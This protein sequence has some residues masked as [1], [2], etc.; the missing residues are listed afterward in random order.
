MLLAAFLLGFPAN[1]IVLPIAVM[2]YLSRGSLG[3]LGELTAL[4]G[5][6]AA[7]GWTGVTA[8]CFLL[9]SLFHFPCSTT[10]LTIRKET[11][12]GKW[13]LLAAAL[14]TAVGMGACFLAASCVRLLSALG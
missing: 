3:E 4:H 12:S 5:L 9:F 1:E 13:T 2:A 8:V 7:N 11:G 6:L 14:P 10:C